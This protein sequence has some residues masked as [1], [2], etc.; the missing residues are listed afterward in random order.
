MATY[1]LGIDQSQNTKSVSHIIMYVNQGMYLL[2]LAGMQVVVGPCRVLKKD[3]SQ[4][5]CCC[6]NNDLTNK[7]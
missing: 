3:Y 4:G 7:T 2:N 6:L 1:R 5:T